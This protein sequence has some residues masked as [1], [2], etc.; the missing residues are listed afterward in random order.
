MCLHVTVTVHNMEDR[1]WR[2][3]LTSCLM[4]KNCSEIRFCWILLFAS[5]LNLILKHCCSSQAGFICLA[6]AE[7]SK[8][9]TSLCCCREQKHFLTLICVSSKEED[10]LQ[11]SARQEVTQHRTPLTTTP[12]P[13]LKHWSPPTCSSIT[14]WLS[15]LNL[16]LYQKHAFLNMDLCLR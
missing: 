6:G 13:E 11:R 1:K 10:K 2:I 8:V 9:K 7:R 3:V 12:P 5:G 4:K 15:K 14:H 16:R